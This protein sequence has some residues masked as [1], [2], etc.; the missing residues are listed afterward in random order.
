M[1][2]NMFDLN[3]SIARHEAEESEEA[4]RKMHSN[5]TGP[6]PLSTPASKALSDKALKARQRQMESIRQRNQFRDL[7]ARPPGS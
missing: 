3:E 7:L 5:K 2:A 6:A 1:P 4:F